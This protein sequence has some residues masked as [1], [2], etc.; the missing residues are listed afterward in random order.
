MNGSNTQQAFWVGFSWAILGMLNMLKMWLT[1]SKTIA[2]KLNEVNP[3]G[4][5]T[6][7]S[8]GGFDSLII[9]TNL[10]PSRV[11]LLGCLS[12]C[13]LALPRIQL[14]NFLV[15]FLLPPL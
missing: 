10:P 15:G 4:G 6:T 14:H 13:H 7:A 5:H 8:F 9:R 11:F 1:W 3:F 12:L 2:L